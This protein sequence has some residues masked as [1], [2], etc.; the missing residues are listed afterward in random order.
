[1]EAFIKIE[2]DGIFAWPPRPPLSV[3]ALRFN[4]FADG[5]GAFGE[6]ARDFTWLDA[7]FHDQRV[8]DGAKEM[9]RGGRVNVGGAI[10]VADFA[11]APMGVGAN[12]RRAASGTFPN[13]PR[14]TARPENVQTDA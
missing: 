14:P 8:V 9:Q 11:P 10:V 4:A 6:A 1:M 3:E 2:S 5:D 7:V 12:W 13:R